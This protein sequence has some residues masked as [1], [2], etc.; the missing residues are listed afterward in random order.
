MRLFQR[1]VVTMERVS[2]TS[3]VNSKTGTLLVT[4]GAELESSV[5]FSLGV[6]VIDARLEDVYH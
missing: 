4:I 5:S 2:L 6:G 1:N 3:S